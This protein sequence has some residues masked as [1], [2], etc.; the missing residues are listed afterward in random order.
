MRFKIILLLVLF[1]ASLLSCG[2]YAL[3]SELDKNRLI[4]VFKGTYESNNP[5][6]FINQY[7]LPGGINGPY[8]QDDSVIKH[9]T[10]PDIYPQAF[11]IDIAEMKL[12][13]VK[14]KKFKFSNYRQP[15]VFFFS[16]ESP[17]YN[18]GG[19]VL[20]NDDVPNNVYVALM[21]YVRKM[22]FNQA[23]QYTQGAAG[24]TFVQDVPGLFEEKI[25]L[26]GYDINLNL[27][28]SYTDSLKLEGMYIN[29]IYPILIPIEG[30]LYFDSQKT[31]Y[32]VLEVRIPV[33]N[34][35]KKY[36][37]TISDITGLSVVHHYSFSDWLRDVH[38]NETNMGGNILTIARGY[39]PTFIGR[40]SGTAPANSLVI[41]IP[42]GEPITNYT[43]PAPVPPYPATSLRNICDFPP[44]PGY[45]AVSLDSVMDYFLEF[46]RYKYEWNQVAPPTGTCANFALYQAEWNAYELEKGNFK[47]P[48]LATWANS[49]GNYVLENISPG[50]YDVYSTDSRTLDNLWYGQLVYDGGFSTTPVNIVVPAG[51]TVTANPTYP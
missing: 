40:I 9:P 49:A 33:K 1:S 26:G 37:S 3:F 29:R 35:I 48:P 21:L 7:G 44:I 16:D 34:Y 51:V 20:K 38:P 12:V 36:E 31:K 23:K 5:R 30:G 18:G 28:N 42:Q 45:N 27:I 46:E 11:M 25:V 17:F 6:P 10:A 14:G 13:D 50:S 32:A 2:D 22:M 24:W 4:V 8:V 15:L 43:T 47:I 39:F 19:Y 41:A